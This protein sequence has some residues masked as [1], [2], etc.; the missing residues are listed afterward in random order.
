MLYI[1]F[2]RVCFSGIPF[3]VYGKR[4]RERAERTAQ[5]RGASGDGRLCERRK[6]LFGG[7][8]VVPFDGVG[9]WPRCKITRVEQAERTV[10]KVVRPVS[11]VRLL[12][13]VGIAET[14]GP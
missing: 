10:K 13:L 2:F 4:P 11:T 8:F 1:Y 14:A 12:P 9:A 5:G 3:R 7:G 6:L